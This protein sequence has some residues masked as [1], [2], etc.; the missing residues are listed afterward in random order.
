MRI[1]TFRFISKLQNTT[2]IYTYTMKVENVTKWRY[3]RTTV[4]NPNFIQAETEF[5]LK[6]GNACHYQAQNLLSSRLLPKN[7]NKIKI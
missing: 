7:E 3:L 6:S 2:P 5:I 1:G 4:T